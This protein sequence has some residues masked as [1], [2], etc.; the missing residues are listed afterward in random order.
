MEVAETL[1][2]LKITQGV[3]S[4]KPCRPLVGSMDNGLSLRGSGGKAHQSCCLFFILKALKWSFHWMEPVLFITFAILIIK[5]V[6]YEVNVYTKC[7]HWLKLWCSTKP[8]VSVQNLPWTVST[9]APK[10]LAASFFL[11]FP[12]YSHVHSSV[13]NLPTC[14]SSSQF[15]SDR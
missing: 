8:V 3:Q 13:C 1:F 14:V 2:S 7:G 11:F 4:R 5:Q 10:C 15:V 6:V 12:F 9:Y